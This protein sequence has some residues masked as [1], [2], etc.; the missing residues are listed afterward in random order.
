YRNGDGLK[1]TSEKIEVIGKDLKVIEVTPLD[2][3]IYRCLATNSAATVSSLNTISLSIPGDQW[4]QIEVEPQDTIANLGSNAVFNCLYKNADVIEWFFKQTG[5][6]ENSTDYVVYS[7]GSL[8]VKN[9]SEQSHGLY[10]CVGIKGES[11]AVPQVYSAYLQTAF[12]NDIDENTIEPEGG[13]VRIVGEGD[14]IELGCIS[15]AGRPKPVVSWEGP[16]LS[17]QYDNVLKLHPVTKKMSGN[18]TCSIS[19]MAGSKKLV[20][21]LIVTSSPQ[22]TQNPLPVLVDEGAD[23]LFRCEYMGT[24]K[25]TKLQWYKDKIQ[26]RGPRFIEKKNFLNITNVQP[27]DRGEYYCQVETEPFPPVYSMPATLTVKEKL[28]FSPRPV[29]KN[30]ELGTVKKV[31]CKAQGSTPPVVKWFK[32]G[33]N[34]EFP[35]HISDINGTLHFNTV[36]ADDKG[37]YTCMAYNPQGVINATIDIDVVVGPKFTVLPKNPTDA[38]EGSLVLMDCVAEGDPKPA[39]HWDKNSAMDNFDKTRFQVLENGSLLIDDV[40]AS[41][42]GKYGCTAG[43]SG[44]L[45]RYEVSLVVRGADGYRV[46]DGENG[47]GG[48][49]M[50]SKTVAITLGAAGAYMVLVI[51]LMAYCRCRSRRNKLALQQSQQPDALR[52]AEGGS[53]GE[54]KPKCNG[55]AAHSDGDITAHSQGSSH[56]KQ[57]YGKLTV[58]RDDLSNNMVLGI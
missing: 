15:P 40:R 27:S 6:L 17:V 35:D 21:Q 11:S 41:D 3:G 34:G 25:H 51:G 7:N 19:N 48:G 57:S 50:L 58:A 33:E 13:P 49:T 4:A 43:N 52:Q 37:K 42:E 54:G 44:G 9:V 45:K 20:V 12:L 2:N 39:I 55:D 14:N 22:I 10:S 28:K 24:T 30:L 56:S 5:P 16:R 26:V 23:A 1:N 53:V 38:Y 46:D 18:Y 31:H 36:Q 29:N 32:D 8:M 47:M